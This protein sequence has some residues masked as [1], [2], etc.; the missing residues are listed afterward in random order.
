MILTKGI[1]SPI[2][3]GQ[4]L[5]K[6]SKW[7]YKLLDKIWL[8]TP[9]YFI[10]NN[11]WEQGSFVNLL[12]K[13]IKSKIAILNY[14]VMNTIPNIKYIDLGC[15]P[16]LSK[17]KAK[18]MEYKKGNFIIHFMFSKDYNKRLAGMKYYSDKAIIN[19]I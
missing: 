19:K 10:K 17:Q 4:W 16:K 9:N 15:S 18:K 13:K 1:S 8:S 14:E 2:N 3:S 5:I 7:S 11:P 12:S 6:N